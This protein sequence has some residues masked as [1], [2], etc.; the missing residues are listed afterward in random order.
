MFLQALKIGNF[1]ISLGLGIFFRVAVV[2]AIDARGF[3]NHIRANLVGAQ[4]GGGVGG[5][6]G[7]AR[8]SAEDDHAALFEM[9]YGAAANERLGHLAHLDGGL[10][11][12][13]H[14]EMLEGILQRERV[15]DGGQH[16]HVIA[17]GA[18]DAGTFA[19]EPAK[20]IAAA[21]DDDHLHAEVAQL[22]DLARHV[23]NGLGTDAEALLTAERLTGEFEQ[24]A[25]EFGLGRG[26]G[27]G[28][29]L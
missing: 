9:P 10:H 1:A 4:R 24:D 13:F 19:L 8:A 20:N 15:D 27:F 18:V 16:A 3:E 6:I 28:C 22:G 26:G 2:N 25:F 12:G 14:L 29:G 17:G 5:K 23:G 11:A 7:V 21:D